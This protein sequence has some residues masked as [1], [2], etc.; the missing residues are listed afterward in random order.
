MWRS[1]SPTDDTVVLHAE[2]DIVERH[3]AS[4]GGAK[5]A[6]RMQ[7]LDRGFEF[8]ASGLSESGSLVKLPP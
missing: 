8:H 2:D 6:A 1:F 5:C 4:P 7:S 3:G